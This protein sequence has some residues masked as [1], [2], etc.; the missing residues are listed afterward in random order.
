MI[1]ERISSAQGSDFKKP[2][3]SAD[4]LSFAI[5]HTYG[6][7]R[8]LAQSY[9]SRERGD[10]TLQATAVVHEAFLRLTR[11]NSRA[12]QGH[13]HFFN[14][15]AREMRRVLID[16]ARCRNS[17]RRGGQA[18]RVALGDAV[19]VEVLGT[20]TDLVALDEALVTLAAKDRRK[21]QVVEL[22]FFGGM[23]IEETAEL[24][25]VSD[26]TVVREWRMAKAWIYQELRRGP[27]AKGSPDEISRLG[28]AG[29][30]LSDRGHSQPD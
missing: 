1:P 2:P 27:R 13:K 8:R 12:W 18:E 11:R 5:L 14:L 28:S 16:H 7:L 6:E 3:A 26:V 25:S 30:A 23:T 9:L 22:R 21:A 19:D 10:H 4:P 29:G 20:D 24:L 15:A 17:V